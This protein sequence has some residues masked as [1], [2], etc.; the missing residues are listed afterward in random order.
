M[1]GWTSADL[2]VSGSPVALRLGWTPVDAMIEAGW[3]GAQIAR[4]ADGK[5]AAPDLARWRA[6]E[7]YLGAEA[8]HT[9]MR[10]AGHDGLSTPQCVA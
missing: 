9:A 10:A 3:Y 1:K 2:T 6:I 7:N 8:K 5:D 4:M